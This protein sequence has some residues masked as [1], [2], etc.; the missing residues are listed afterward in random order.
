MIC[1]VCGEEFPEENLNEEGICDNCISSILQKDGVDL[2]L[3]V[4]FD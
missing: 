4:E 3:G 1:K 2:G